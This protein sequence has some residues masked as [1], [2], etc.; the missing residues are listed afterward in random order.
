[1]IYLGKNPSHPM[2]TKIDSNT[3]LDNVP[4]NKLQNILIVVDTNALMSNLDMVDDLK[5]WDN[6][7]TIL[8]LRESILKLPFCSQLINFINIFFKEL[9]YIKLYIMINASNEGIFVKF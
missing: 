6:A 8:N 7:G 3:K 5:D 4:L 2:Q 9:A 1:M